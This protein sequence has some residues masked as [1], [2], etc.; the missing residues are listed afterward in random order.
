MWNERLARGC[1]RKS[2]DGS[3][4][5]RDVYDC[6]SVSTQKRQSSGKMGLSCWVVT[7]DRQDRVKDTSGVC[8][9]TNQPSTNDS[10]MGSQETQS[11]GLSRLSHVHFRGVCRAFC[12]LPSTKV[13]SAEAWNL[14]TFVMFRESAVLSTLADLLDALRFN[15][16]D[17]LLVELCL[18][19]SQHNHCFCR[20]YCK[21]A[22]ICCRWI[23]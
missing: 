12:L 11:N 6:T 23:C 10:V 19:L 9:R 2:C 22:Y 4:T 14:F 13:L 15:V 20:H 1:V 16:A 17:V 8:F 18:K 5:Y 21:L 7:P 3:P